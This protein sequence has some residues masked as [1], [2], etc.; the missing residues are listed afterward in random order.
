MRTEQES[1]GE[2]HFFDGHTGGSG[3]VDSGTGPVRGDVY[4]GETVCIL[5]LGSFGGWRHRIF[6]DSADD[7]IFTACQVSG[8]CM[9]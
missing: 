3:G 2:I 6:S 7:E 1:S 9:L 8:I 5:F 4:I